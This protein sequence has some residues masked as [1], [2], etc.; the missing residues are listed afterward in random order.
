MCR[1]L[2]MM[3]EDLRPEPYTGITYKI[4]YRLFKM[5]EMKLNCGLEL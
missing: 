3:K 5:K 1:L 2:Y 4:V